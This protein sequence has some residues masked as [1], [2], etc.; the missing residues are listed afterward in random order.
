MCGL[1]RHAGVRGRR[2]AGADGIEANLFVGIVVLLAGAINGIAM[3]RAYFYL[4]TGTRHASTVALELRWRER[5]AVLT[6]AALILG[7]GLYPQP[8][9][10]SRHQ[11]ATG[12]LEKREGGRPK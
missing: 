6:L 12:I 2:V 9:V 5:V 7:G 10:A 1:S 4:F 11:A 8:G 3:L